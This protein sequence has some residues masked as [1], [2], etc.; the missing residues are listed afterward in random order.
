MSTCDARST[1]SSAAELTVVVVLPVLLAGVLSASVLVAE[2]EL[3]TT[4]AEVDETVMVTVA[5]APD[6]IEPR[7]AVTV[8]LEPTG[9]VTSEPCDV[10]AE[11]KF[12]EAGSTS[13]S[14][15]PDAPNGVPT[16]FTVIV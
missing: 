15:T 2:A 1:F 16:F 5:V 11:T 10:V 8:P 14:V 12:S 7:F 3:V 6:A 9:G 13:V 4:P